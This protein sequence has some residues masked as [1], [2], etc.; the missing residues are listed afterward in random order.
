MICDTQG[1]SWQWN[2]ESLTMLGSNAIS[3]KYLDFLRKIDH[4]IFLTKLNLFVAAMGKARVPLLSFVLGTKY[5][6]KGWYAIKVKL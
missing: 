4:V 3:N 6:W 2:T 1:L 5:V